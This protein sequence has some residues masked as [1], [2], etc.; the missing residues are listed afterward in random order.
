MKKVLSNFVLQLL[1]AILFSSSAYA[2]FGLMLGSFRNKDGAQEFQKT[3]IKQKYRPNQLNI[4]KYL[5][6]IIFKLTSI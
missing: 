5:F 4:L 6:F 3:L 2:D 1:L